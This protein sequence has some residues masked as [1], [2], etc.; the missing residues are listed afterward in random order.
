MR[1]QLDYCECM[2]SIDIKQS[3]MDDCIIAYREMEAIL[4]QSSWINID[5]AS[6][7]RAGPFSLDKAFHYTARHKMLLCGKMPVCKYES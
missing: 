3:S 2:K 1:V 6:G 5:T 7:F 4:V